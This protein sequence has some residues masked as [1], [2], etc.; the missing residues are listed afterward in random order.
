[1]KKKKKKFKEVGV[2]LPRKFHA[3][4]DHDKD[5]W[6]SFALPSNPPFLTTKQEKKKGGQALQ[7][8]LYTL[9]S[10][11]VRSWQCM[12]PPLCH[13]FFNNNNEGSQAF[14]FLQCNRMMGA[15]ITLHSP[16]AMVSYNATN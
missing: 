4:K 9:G 14:E 8:N 15:N 1:M 12:H 13:N 7:L 3:I 5:K 10:C 16:M 11:N 6:A 2:G